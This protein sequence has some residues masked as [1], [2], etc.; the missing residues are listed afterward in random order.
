MAV[1]KIAHMAPKSPAMA[2]RISMRLL[3]I[4]RENQGGHQQS[5]TAA[6]ACFTRHRHH[7]RNS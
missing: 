6:R 1:L 3:Q 4:W 7:F 5:R 2:A